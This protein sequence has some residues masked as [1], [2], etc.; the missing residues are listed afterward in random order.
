M[1]FHT[2]SMMHE[3]HITK[4]KSIA[5]KGAASCSAKWVHRFEVTLFCVGRHA[6]LIKVVLTTVVDIMNA[7]KCPRM[8]TFTPAY[9]A[10]LGLRYQAHALPPTHP[11][12]GTIKYG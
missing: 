8:P 7:S 3:Y 11:T 1:L 6:F 10:H 12:P 4:A 2:M 5:E 9:P